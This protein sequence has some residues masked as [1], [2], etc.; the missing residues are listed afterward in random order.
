MDI[1]IFDLGTNA[2]VFWTNGSGRIE[3]W[4]LDPAHTCC[5][6]GHRPKGL[7]DRGENGGVLFERLKAAALDVIG[8]LV[9]MG[10]HTFITGMAPGFD[11]MAAQLLIERYAADERIDL[12][13]AVPYCSQIDEL[14]SEQD[15]LLYQKALQSAKAVVVFFD[16]KTD[17]CYKTRNRFMVNYSSAVIAYCASKSPR[18]GTLQTLRMAEKAGLKIFRVG[19]DGV[20]AE[21][22]D[23]ADNRQ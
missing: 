11:L 12:V 14:H 4:E 6:T 23:N 17:S 18:S 8:K 5:F 15:I 20:G 19:I 3:S 16:K 21:G 7:P 13:C 10:Y 22:S 1:S 2:D 9:D